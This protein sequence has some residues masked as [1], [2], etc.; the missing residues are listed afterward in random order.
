MNTVS[1]QTRKYELKAR[2]ESQRETRDRI[3]R[4]AAELHEEKGVAHTTVAEIARQA[5]VT[6][7]TVYNHFATLGDLLPACAAHYATLHPAPDFATALA[8]D[9]PA[10]R[11]GTALAQ[12]YAWYRE[13]EPMTAHVLRDAEAVPALRPIV[14]GGL[15]R[16]LGEAQRVLTEP[17]EA[18][19]LRQD[20][21]DAAA[22]GAIDVHLWRA[23]APLGDDVAA[24][25]AASL[26]ERAADY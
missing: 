25:L 14:E 8:L 20:R 23:L 15:L 26:V 18:H 11:V 7:L 19:G 5:G 3:A 9:D 1:T 10:E 4:A 2:A 13:T 22:R 17:F 24:E 12:L 16:Y 21:L 6:R